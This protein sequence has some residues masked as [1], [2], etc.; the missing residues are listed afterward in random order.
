MSLGSL[1]AIPAKLTPKGR[2]FGSKPSG[3]GGVGSA[4]RK[5]KGTT[6]VG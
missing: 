3:I 4:S 2:G 1:H 6:T 5:A